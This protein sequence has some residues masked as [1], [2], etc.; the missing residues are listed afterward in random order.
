MRKD[1]KRMVKLLS[2][3]DKACS[4]M[5]VPYYLIDGELLSLIRNVRSYEA[6]ADIC[7]LYDDYLKIVPV[8]K[9][10]RKRK[11]ESIKNNI[12]MPGIYFRYVDT[13]T[14]MY[15]QKYHKVRKM[16]GIA[17]NVHILRQVNEDSKTL[18]RLEEVMETAIEGSDKDLTDELSSMKKIPF[19]YKSKMTGMLKNA[20]LSDLDDESMLKLPGQ[21]VMRFPEGFWKGQSDVCIGRTE[22]KTLV[23]S[24]QY[25]MIRY[26]EDYLTRKMTRLSE[27]Y[28]V[29]SDIDIP[30][31]KVVGKMDS[32]LDEDPRYRG[33]HERYV[34]FYNDE[35]TD[36]VKQEAD[37]WD[38][39][40][41]VEDRIMMWKMYETRKETVVKL[42]EEGRNDEVFMIMEAYFNCVKKYLKKDKLL[43]FDDD[44]WKICSRLWT[45]F[46]YEEIVAKAE[47]YL[48][49]EYAVPVNDEE[50]KKYYSGTVPKEAVIIRKTT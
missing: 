12:D 5:Q 49:T 18:C 15:V 35:Y 1:E 14:L 45:E 32:F 48:D 19:L 8:I 38:I 23:N 31:K 7:M 20:A 50:L 47:E 16:H 6:E 22:L 25:L 2:E 17:V 21:E 3:L 41:F 28:Q 34:R 26:G 9:K 24:E 27:N 30:F 13:G 46:G 40:F 43:Y 10:N 4:V 44:Y 36:L 29:I 39:L 42:L 11:I 37:Y 33:A